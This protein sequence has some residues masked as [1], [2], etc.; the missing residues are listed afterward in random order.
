MTVRAFKSGAVEFLTKPFVDQDL[1]NAIQQ[2]F[3]RAHVSRM[4]TIAE[5]SSDGPTGNL[6]LIVSSLRQHSPAFA[7][8]RCYLWKK[9]E[10]HQSCYVVRGQLHRALHN[11]H[12]RVRRLS[13]PQEKF[14]T[15]RYA[16]L[17]LEGTH[18]D[19]LLHFKR[20]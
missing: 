15:N 8:N 17:G 2:A 18:H 12:R 11:W 19:L 16:A 9:T 3:D 6:V 20:A 13:F 1:L 4:T 14:I 10:W 5:Q 7:P